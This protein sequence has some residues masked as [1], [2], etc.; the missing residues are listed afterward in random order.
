MPYTQH[1]RDVEGKAAQAAMFIVPKRTDIP[2]GADPNRY[3]I[4]GTTGTNQ[5]G[6]VY[7]VGSQIDAVREGTLFLGKPGIPIQGYESPNGAQLD[8]HHFQLAII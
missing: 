2:A 7:F 6:Q 4:V 3:F 8:L 5:N 1:L